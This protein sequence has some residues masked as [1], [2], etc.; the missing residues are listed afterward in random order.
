MYQYL[1]SEKYLLLRQVVFLWITFIVL[2][3]MVQHKLPNRTVHNIVNI[4]LALSSIV[5]LVIIVVVSLR[6][7]F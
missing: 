3:V 6:Y 7:T 4:F 1:F 5:E 2:L